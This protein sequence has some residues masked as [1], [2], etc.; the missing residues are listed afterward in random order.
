MRKKGRWF[1]RIFFLI[2]ICGGR[3]RASAEEADSSSASD[4]AKGIPTGTTVYAEFDTIGGL[5]P[6]IVTPGPAP[7]LVVTDIEVPA[8]E[9]VTIQPGVVFLFR[10]FTGLHA[11]G[12]LKAEGT[13]EQPIV[14]TSEFDR[15]YNPA[16]TLLA[17]PFDWNGIYLHENAVGSRLAACIIKYSVFGI[18]SATK[19]IRISDSYFNANGKSDFIVEGAN[20]NIAVQ[21]FSY[22][23]SVNEAAVNGVPVDIL[24]DPAAPKRQALRYC[25]LVTF[26]GGTGLG[27]AYTV[28]LVESRHD[29][30]PDRE[31]A[32]SREANY[33]LAMLGGYVLGCLGALGFA[34]SFTF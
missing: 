22:A 14:F 28:K 18:N 13:K 30:A 12:K 6:A 23:L 33:T 11:Q 3:I 31:N 29:A 9:T 19:F 25:G 17:N 1:L 21:P 20:Q 10:S 32:R 8:G 27:V 34:V 2:A 7:Y 4:S 26:L 24:E 15:T 16:C 5:L